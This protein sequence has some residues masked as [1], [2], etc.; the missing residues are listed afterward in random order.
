MGV[1]QGV[2]GV[3]EAGAAAMVEMIVAV[4]VVVVVNII[5]LIIFIAANGRLSMRV[6]GGLGIVAGVGWAMEWGY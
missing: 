5:V 2:V 4:I 1:V 6:S 3:V